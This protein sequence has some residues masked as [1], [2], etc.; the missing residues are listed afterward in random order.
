MRIVRNIIL[1]ALLSALAMGA[2]GASQSTKTAN[3][4]ALADAIYKPLQY[5][6]GMV[7]ACNNMGATLKDKVKKLECENE[8]LNDAL[9]KIERNLKGVRGA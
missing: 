2:L 9:K 1:I 8:R 3:S 5:Y 6:N 7:F 4:R